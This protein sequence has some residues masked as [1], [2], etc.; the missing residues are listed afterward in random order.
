MCEL[1]STVFLTFW[2]DLDHMWMVRLSLPCSA[3]SVGCCD[4]DASTPSGR[5]CGEDA[6]VAMVTGSEPLLQHN[7]GS[8]VI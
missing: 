7:S 1:I 6:T 3:L 8:L 4:E 2:C 5:D